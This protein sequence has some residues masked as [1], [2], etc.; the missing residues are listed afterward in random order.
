MTDEQPSLGADGM[1]GRRGS[2]THRLDTSRA[3][4]QDIEDEMKALKDRYCASSVIS[5]SPACFL[6]LIVIHMCMC[7]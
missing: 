6:K 1:S 3:V 4:S 5:C 7:V 2:K